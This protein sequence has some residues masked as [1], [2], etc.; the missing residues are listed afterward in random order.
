MFNVR[1]VITT[2]TEPDIDGI[3]CMYAY[4]ELLKKRGENAEIFFEGKP[5]KEV[6]II[7]EK[8]K[9]KL[10]NLNKISS[11]DKV[12]LVDNNELSFLPRCIN[13]NQIVEIIDHHP[14]REWL[15]NNTD[16]RCQIE[17]IGA[18]ATLVAERYY[19][20]NVEISRE[21][22][23]LLYYGIISNTMNLK[24][25]LTSDRDIKM[26]KWLKSKA[27]EIDDSITKEIFIKKSDIGNNLKSEMEVGDKNPFVKIKWSIGQLEVANVDDFLKKY[28]D[29]IRAILK[30]VAME[31]DIEYISVN[32]MDILNG[33]N[34]VIAG[35]QKTADMLTENFEFFNFENLKARTDRFISRKEIVKV[36]AD[37]YRK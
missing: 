7:L 24:I 23:I 15:K 12:I 14:M 27:T 25:K 34:V 17:L 18:A 31:K 2:Y 6:E 26:A 28:E 9:I 1:K 20:E 13:K 29:E 5:K 32:I 11:T 37:K 16:V 22:A 19:N 3:G 10:H 21:S 35:N 8:F 30:N 36:I 33:Y 4:A